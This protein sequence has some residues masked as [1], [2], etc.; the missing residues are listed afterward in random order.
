MVVVEEMVEGKV[1]AV[2]E[3]LSDFAFLP[4]G[5][6]WKCFFVDMDLDP[7]DLALKDGAHYQGTKAAPQG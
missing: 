7:K 6:P 3:L 4:A 1:V 5:L 2:A